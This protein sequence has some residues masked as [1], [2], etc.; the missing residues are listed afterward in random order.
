MV[1]SGT[2]AIKPLSVRPAAVRVAVADEDPTARR[3]MR[4]WLEQAGYAVVEASS[5]QEGQALISD[6]PDIVC[7]DLGLGQGTGEELLKS[8][9]ANYPH[10][11][12]VVVTAQRDAETAVAAMRAG[13]YDY[14]TKPMDCDRL[15]HAVAR[16]QE[17][18]DLWRNVQ[19]L[20][21][22]LAGRSLAGAMGGHSEGIR[23]L[24]ANV[25]RV[26]D[27][28]VSV[29]LSGETGS[30]KELVA[31][32]IHQGSARC[33][34]PYVRVDCAAFEAAEQ[35]AVLFG[36]EKPAGAVSCGAFEQASGGVLYLENVSALSAK[37]QSALAQ[38]LSSK[39]VSRVGGADAIAV[40]VRV[41]AA[42]EK[43]LRVFVEQGRFRE[44]L[45]FRLVVYPI[46]VPP[47][48]SRKDDIPLV[49]SHFLRELAPGDGAPRH[50]APEALEA[51]MRYSWPGNIRELEHV[52]HRS[53]LTTRDET[54][55]LPDLPPEVRGGTLGRFD[56]RAGASPSDGS[57][58][59][60]EMNFPEN[61]VIPLRELERRAIEHAL[62]V[63]GG[64]VSVAAQKLGIG[65]ATL[66]RRI[67]SFDISQHVA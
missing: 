34:G 1:N 31:R 52:V 60:D 18:R 38:V 58:L 59:V 11:P 44:D 37:A 13:A 19:R 67:A 48:R 51:L 17:R 9:H 56:E 27:R 46:T 5:I 16:A 2:N 62:R 57:R 22:E 64:S 20:E 15:L 28:D 32:A 7:V 35:E 39:R 24:D 42:D 63:T 26:I 30:G 3:L 54:I 25:A 36:E 4:H 10:V 23:E 14:V 21:Q 66:Y 47:L 12:V 61:E 65:R 49:V 29:C 43:D 45:F 33:H 53:L 40:N 50:V 6:P 8:L 55:G 41:I